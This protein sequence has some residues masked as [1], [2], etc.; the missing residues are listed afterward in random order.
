[1]DFEQ[2]YNE[3][4]EELMIKAAETGAD[5]EMGFDAETF[6]EYEYEK[7]LRKEAGI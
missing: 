4:E 6:T 7:Y 5:R 2:W 3:N 1:M